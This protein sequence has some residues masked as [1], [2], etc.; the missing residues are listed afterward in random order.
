MWSFALRLLGPLCFIIYLLQRNNFIQQVWQNSDLHS[1]LSYPVYDS[2][3]MFF[4]KTPVGA[5]CHDRQNERGAYPLKPYTSHF[6][7]YHTFIRLTQRSSKSSENWCKTME[8]CLA[9]GADRF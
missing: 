7:R 3:L 2:D 4:N 9:R 1:P 8:A 6:D 5:Y